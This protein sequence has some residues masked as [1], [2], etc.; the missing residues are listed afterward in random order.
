MDPG[1]KRALDRTLQVEL[2]PQ[3]TEYGNVFE[4]FVILEI[5]KNA[6]Y[7]RFDWSYSYSRTKDGVEIDLIVERPGMKNLMIEIK[8]RARI[9]QA[10]AYSLETLG[11]DIDAKAEKWVLSR[12]P[13]EQKWG[14]VR[15][16][17]W[18]R[19]VE[20]LFS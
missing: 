19:G 5:I 1:I 15:A 20:I 8:S 10:D 13:L 9:T 2:L 16:L 4:H 7:C 17:P 18:Q 12:D 6:S 3:T 11:T 14:P